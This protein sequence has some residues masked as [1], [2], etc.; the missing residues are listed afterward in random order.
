MPVP[1]VRPCA[2]VIEKGGSSS[3]TQGF[4][5]TTEAVLLVLVFVAGALQA[6]RQQL[7]G[8]RDETSEV[9]SRQE[10]G[11]QHSHH[12]QVI[13]WTGI[14]LGHAASRHDMLCN[15]PGLCTHA[16]DAPQNQLSSCERCAGL[17][18]N[19]RE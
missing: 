13:A 9:C 15:T 16:C 7:E 14:R 4:D 1:C 2:P 6:R 11:A 8:N 5:A 12:L 18:G 10:A 17:L 19:S 3:A